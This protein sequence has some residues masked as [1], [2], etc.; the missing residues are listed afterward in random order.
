MGLLGIIG[1]SGWLGA[2]FGTGLLEKRLWPTEGLVLLNRSGPSPAYAAF[3]GVTW[4]RDA[5]EL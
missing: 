3:P 2:A 1:A 5:T 4:A